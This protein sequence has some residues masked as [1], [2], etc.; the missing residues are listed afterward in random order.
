MR[1]NLFVAAESF[2]LDG[3]LD[4]HMD[5]VSSVLASNGSIRVMED[6]SNYGDILAV[7]AVLSGQADDFP[8]NISLENED[9][10]AKLRSIYWS[11][12]QVT[13][14]SNTN[15]MAIYVKRLS[16]SEG[17]E[18]HG[19]NTAQKQ[20]LMGLTG[21]T[22]VVNSIVNESIFTKLSEDEFAEARD[23]VPKDISGQRQ[24]V[25][26]AAVS[27]N[28]KVSYFWGGKS[29]AY[30]WDERWG[31]MRT[32]TDETSDS[33][34]TGKPLG[35]DCSGFVSW[36]FLNTFNELD[37][38]GDGSSKQW[39]KSYEVEWS[40]ALPGDIVFYN[41]PSESGNHVGI[42]LSVNASGP[43]RIVHCGGDGVKITGKGSFAIARRPYVYRE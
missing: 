33:Y 10:V 29:L 21:K 25:L 31:E 20:T 16:A 6:N 34:G 27:L 36:A 8:Y 15:G 17:A 2:A 26:L 14:V 19:L 28:Q 3:L 13:G 7:Y 43:D 9:A 11:M 38:I 23:L 39:E 18:L 22:S 30:G 40:A 32:I 12:T 37:S 4:E 1:G 42:V 35:L 5:E 24:A 41:E